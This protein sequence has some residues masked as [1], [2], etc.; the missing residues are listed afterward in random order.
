MTEAVSPPHDLEEFLN[1]IRD[2]YDDLSDRLQR[3]ARHILDEPNDLAF[4]T[5]AVAAKRST[6]QPSTIV[7]FAQAFGCSGASPMQRLV[8]EGLLRED[9]SLG[10]AE[11]IRQHLVHPAYAGAD[12]GAHPGR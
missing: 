1:M 12:S 11:R 9:R 4:E 7:R 10:Y 5:L 6:V 3:I 8:R 2:R